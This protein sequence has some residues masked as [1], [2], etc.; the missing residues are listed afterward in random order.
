M[1][2][3][4]AMYLSIPCTFPNFFLNLMWYLIYIHLAAVA[5]LYL[6]GPT[7]GKGLS[8]RVDAELQMSLNLLDMTRTGPNDTIDNC[9]GHE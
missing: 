6:P 1:L 5:A 8:A 9:D 3:P 4:F 2:L 7:M